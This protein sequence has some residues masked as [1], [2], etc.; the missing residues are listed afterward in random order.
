MLCS[1]RR[2]LV[3]GHAGGLPQR[4]RQ[5]DSVAGAGGAAEGVRAARGGLHHQDRAV[6]H[7][8]VAQEEEAAVSGD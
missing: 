4:A 1:G 7:A 3:A 8:G 5:A 2:Q 6:R